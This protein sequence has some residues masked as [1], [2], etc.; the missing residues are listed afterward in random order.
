[1]AR[2]K[3]RFVCRE[4][5]AVTPRWMGQCPT[6]GAWDA[7]EEEIVVP[8]S[9]ARPAAVAEPTPRPL[10]E[11]PLDDVMRWDTGDP[12]FNRV[13]GGGLVR[14]SLVLFGGAPGIGKSTLLLQT[15]LRMRTHPILYVAGEESPRQIRMRARRLGDAEADHI[16]VLDETAVET[17]LEAARHR[18]PHVLI[19]DS[20]HTLSSAAVEGPPGSMAQLKAVT[21]QLM[22]LARD[23]QAAVFLVG[24]VTKEGHVAGPRLVEHMVDTVLYLEGDRRMGF[25]L[26]RTVKNRFGAVSEIGVYSM[27]ARG[28][29]PVSD[30]SAYFLT[31]RAEPVSGV[32]WG[33][34]VEGIRPLLLEVQALVSPTYYQLPQ[35]A[36]T[37]FDAKRLQ[38][39]LAVLEKRAR[40]P[41]GSQDVFLNI[42]GGLRVQDTALDLPVAMAL[43]SAHADRPV[44]PGTI[45]IGEVGLTGELRPVP[46]MEMRIQEALRH[47]PQQV[48]VP[49][50][51][52]AITDRRIRPLATVADVIAHL[53]R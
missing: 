4:C 12:E 45:F 53:G 40:I 16:A 50:S 52:K 29:E 27:T 38:M 35:R 30:P 8:S 49:Q 36:A 23:L 9:S 1:M 7:L 22:H 19:I 24:H 51:V 33:V 44:P 46:A 47:R 39:L 6:C 17:V 20:L 11:V 5:G 3:R 21:Y 18:N 10:A 15:A 48:V 43:A 42:T 14:G 28:L 31:E 34:I 41:I 32:A 25:R 2:P 26:L 13:L 37:G